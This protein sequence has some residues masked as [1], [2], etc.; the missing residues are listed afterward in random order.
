MQLSIVNADRTHNFLYLIK[1]FDNSITIL[2]SGIDLK[3]QALRLEQFL[4][5]K[6]H[7]VVR[8]KVF[9]TINIDMV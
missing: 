4:Y 3:T 9:R 8:F 1:L 2:G 6:C 5:Y 7:I